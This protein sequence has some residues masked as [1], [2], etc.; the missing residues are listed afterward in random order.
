MLVIYEKKYIQDT[1]TNKMKRHYFLTDQLPMYEKDLGISL[2]SST[3]RVRITNEIDSDRL[4]VPPAGCH[5][6][7]HLVIICPTK[8]ISY[9][10]LN[11]V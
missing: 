11:L 7:Y 2:L 8:K 3:S 10:A 4:K 5:V 9:S 6:G 1:I